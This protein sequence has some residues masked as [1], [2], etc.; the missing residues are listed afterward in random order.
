MLSYARFPVALLAFVVGCIVCSTYIDAAPANVIINGNYV[1]DD[2]DVAAIWEQIQRQEAAQS[3]QPPAETTESLSY[4]FEFSEGR[5]APVSAEQLERRKLMWEIANS[6]QSLGQTNLVIPNQDSITTP[7][8]RTTAKPVTTTATTTTRRPASS[9]SSISR[10][11][12]PRE[13][14]LQMALARFQSTSTEPSEANS[15]GSQRVGPTTE[16]ATVSCSICLDQLFEDDRNGDTGTRCNHLQ[17]TTTNPIVT[18]PTTEMPTTTRTTLRPTEATTTLTTSSENPTP[19]IVIATVAPTTALTTTTTTSSLRPTSQSPTI[20]ITPS[21][22][23][24]SQP[25]IEITSTRT[26][27][28]TSDPRDM[29]ADDVSMEEILRRIEELEGR[30][31]SSTQSP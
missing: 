31:I 7:R 10:P 1:D 28:T 11:L 5:R 20:L 16:S 6:G 24:T 23:T 25:S 27:T 18:T 19:A 30:A 12:N 2:T 8:L 4:L 22:I 29:V 13:A 15:A 3:A 26:R 17:S 14:A 21:I 9:T